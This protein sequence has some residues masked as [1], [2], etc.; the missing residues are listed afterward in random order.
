MNSLGPETIFVQAHYFFYLEGSILM[1][2]ND[3]NSTGV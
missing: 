2:G 1:E 3:L